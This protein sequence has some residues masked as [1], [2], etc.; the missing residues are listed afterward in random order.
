L[1]GCRAT[2]GPIRFGPVKKM[3]QFPR[4]ARWLTLRLPRK[5]PFSGVFT[6][7]RPESYVKWLYFSSMKKQHLQ[8]AQ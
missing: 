4:F 7:F 1:A 3:Q 8:A 5:W 2:G 6:N